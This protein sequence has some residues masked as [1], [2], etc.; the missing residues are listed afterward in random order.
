[1]VGVRRLWCAEG[2]ITGVFTCTV[3]LFVR[4]QEPVVRPRRR[5]HRTPA[6]S[7]V[8]HR[9]RR[10]PLHATQRYQTSHA[11]QRV[12]ATCNV[13]LACDAT[14]KMQGPTSHLRLHRV[15]TPRARWG[16][17]SAPATTLAGQVLI[18]RHL[19]RDALTSPCL[20]CHP[21]SPW[22]SSLDLLEVVGKCDPGLQP[23][24]SRRVCVCSIAFLEPWL[25]FGAR[26]F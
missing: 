15:R 1:M 6:A 14:G 2:G 3:R 22:V 5:Q 21:H 24:H 7:H 20:D 19:R 18:P 26:G 25:Q 12:Q 10:R 17:L 4:W 16:W 13:D 23:R 11:T 8:S 9:M